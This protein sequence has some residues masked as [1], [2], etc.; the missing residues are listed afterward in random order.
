MFALYLELLMNKVVEMGILY[1]LPLEMQ[2]MKY[3]KTKDLEE[4]IS[5]RDLENLSLCSSIL[6]DVLK[7]WVCW[8]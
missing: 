6:L 5:S 2:G 7:I 4:Y 8:W 1:F 3:D